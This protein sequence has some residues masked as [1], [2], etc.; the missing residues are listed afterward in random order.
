[1]NTK[2]LRTE[3]NWLREISPIRPFV[4]LT[5]RSQLE[6][7]LRNVLLITFPS[8]M[9]EV[10][11]E[12]ERVEN[13]LSDDDFEICLRAFLVLGMSRRILGRFIGCGLNFYHKPRH[14]FFLGNFCYNFRFLVGITQ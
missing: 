11:Q 2:C 14:T 9:T 6:K 8:G 7:M 12:Y 13:I 3:F 10:N 1:M 5:N 4:I